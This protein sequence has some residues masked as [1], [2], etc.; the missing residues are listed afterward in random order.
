MLT[1]LT[2]CTALGCS[3]TNTTN[4][5]SG[6]DTISIPAMGPHQSGKGKKLIEYC[7]VVVRAYFAIMSVGGKIVKHLGQESLCACSSL[8]HSVELTAVW[9]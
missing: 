1:M 9:I 6:H 4:T 8:A 2:H 7:C 3:K 5:F